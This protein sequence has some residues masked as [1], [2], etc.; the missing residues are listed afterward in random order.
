MGRQ[1]EESIWE[2]MKNW[3]YLEAD[4]ERYIALL[5]EA[6]SHDKTSSRRCLRPERLKVVMIRGGRRKGLLTH[7]ESRSPAVL[8]IKE[9]KALWSNRCSLYPSS[10]ACKCYQTHV[11]GP[12]RS[13]VS[14]KVIVR[15]EHEWSL[16]WDCCSG[17]GKERLKFKCS[18]AEK[19]LRNH[20][21]C[22]FHPQL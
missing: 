8:K 12:A 4:Q 10:K 1:R 16:N 17:F 20:L 15:L 13:C 6:G 2:T 11:G 7:G 19:S 9:F 5:W 21:L 3:E 14:I 22:G 18:R